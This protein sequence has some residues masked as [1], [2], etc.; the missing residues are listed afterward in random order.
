M[1]TLLTIIFTVIATVLTY[2]TETVSLSYNYN[3]L[4]FSVGYNDGNNKNGCEIDWRFKGMS[5]QINEYVETKI[6]SGEL[7]D[8][9]FNISFWLF[10]A[11]MY[12]CC[13][14]ELSQNKNGYYVNIVEE[15]IGLERMVQIVDYFCSE[16]WESFVCKDS[17]TNQKASINTLFTRIDEVVGKTDLSFINKDI[18]VYE[19]NQ[20][21]INY[22][23]DSL[24]LTIDN[25][26]IDVNINLKQTSIV[27]KAIDSYYFFA[28]DDTVYVYDK[29]ILKLKNK[30]PLQ[31][32]RNAK[33]EVLILKPMLSMVFIQNSIFS[34]MKGFYL[35]M[36]L[37]RKLN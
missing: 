19:L 31:E 33:I 17:K 22:V 1:K 7:K 8:K 12:D 23:N 18:V 35:S 20:L 29:N 32:S 27:P 11:S 36:I 25:I 14:I 21:R 37:L 26:Q 28:S 6:K 15:E 4:D 13:P 10:S 3:H 5:V 16:Q 24:V 30:R 9:K 2:G 34:I